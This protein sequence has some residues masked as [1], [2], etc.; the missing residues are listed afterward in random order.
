[1][2]IWLSLYQ[3]AQR[4]FQCTEMVQLIPPLTVCL[5]EGKAQV[6][7]KICLPHVLS[8]EAIHCEA[9][10]FQNVSQ[11]QSALAFHGKRLS[12]RVVFSKFLDSKAKREPKTL[13]PPVLM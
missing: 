12:S 10:K 3:Y 7:N 5:A 9:D 2:R 11:I 4:I 6:L 13:W 8:R 1:M